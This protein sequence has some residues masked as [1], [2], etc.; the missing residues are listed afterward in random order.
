M[1]SLLFVVAMVGDTPADVI[2]PPAPR[3]AVVVSARPAP[4]HGA[5]CTQTMPDG[6]AYC[7]TSDPQ[8]PTPVEESPAVTDPAYS[9]QLDAMFCAAKPWSCETYMDVA[10]DIRSGAL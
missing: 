2:P 6:S 9:A 5:P 1:I 7:G 10:N 8:E 3:P 4:P